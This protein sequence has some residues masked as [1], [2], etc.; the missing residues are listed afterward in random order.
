MAESPWSSGDLPLTVAAANIGNL[1]YQSA[2][3]GNGTPYTTMGIKVMNAGGL[4]SDFAVMTV[5]VTSVN[6]APTSTG[7]SVSLNG[8]HRQDVCGW[9]TSRS[10]MSMPATRWVRSR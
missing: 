7:G 9:Q 8:R 10:R 6:D 4:W 3:N 1:T 5:N 2:L